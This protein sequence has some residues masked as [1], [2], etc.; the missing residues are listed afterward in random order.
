M[1]VRPVKSPQ[2]EAQSQIG[3]KNTATSRGGSPHHVSHA[4]QC[5]LVREPF[6]PY[7]ACTLTLSMESP[8]K[9]SALLSLEN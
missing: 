3:G 8:L 6:P 2:D 1:G 9:L 7:G 4:D 5:T